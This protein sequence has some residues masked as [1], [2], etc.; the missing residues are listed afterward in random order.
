MNERASVFET[1]GRDSRLYDRYT[2]NA[3]DEFATTETL[4][5][6]QAEWE[7]F[8]VNSHGDIFDGLDVENPRE[9][10][11]IDTL[12]YDFVVDQV[13]EFAERQ[14][15]FRVVNQEANDN[16][17]ALSFD[18]QTLHESVVD[19]DAI[20]RT[21]DELLDTVDLVNSD[22]DFLRRLYESVI[23]NEMRLQL[24]EYYTPKG[25]AELAVGE[26]EVDDFETD[27]VLDPGCGSGIFLATCVDAKREALDL[28][29]G[30]LV[31][32]ITDT[33]YG[34]DLNPVAVKSAKL[35]YLLSLLPV[36]ADS[37]VDRL[38]LPVFLTDSLGLTRDDRIRFGDDTLDLTVDHLVGN[39]PWIT[40]G[41]LSESV[42]D[43]WRETYVTQLDLLPHDGVESRL[44]HGNDDISVPFLWV[45]IHHYLDEGGDASF[46]LKRDITKGPAG[47]LLRTQHVNSR[48]V[49]V[50][51]IHDFNR[52]RPFGDDVGV[53][54]AVYTLA[55]DSEPSFPIAVDSW[56]RGEGAT[57][58][59][60]AEAMRETLDYEETGMV[61][62]EEDDTSS[63]WV[64]ED[65]E[66]QALG[67]C[68]HDIRHGVKDDAKDV[69]GVE[70]SQLDELEHDHV[71]PYIQSKHVVK[72]GLFGHDLHLVPVC[73]A[74]E[75]NET[76]LQ[77]NC[78]KTYGYLESNRQT[79]EDRSS[80]WLDEGTFYNV[81][82]LGEYTWSDY[83]VVWC[84]LGFKPHFAVVSTV[85]DEDLDEKMVVPGDHF[86]FISTDDEY[87]AHFL[88]GLL[89]SS[90]YQTSLEGVASEGKSSLT[91][92][93]VSGLELP[94]Y[95]ETED[96]ERLA[97]LSM[98]AHEIVPEHTDVSKRTYNETSIEEL[99]VVQAEIDELVEEM[100]SERAGSLFPDVGQSTLASY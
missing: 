66:N 28:D 64:R 37:D 12:Y 96:S 33:V 17:D 9:S 23:S 95:R 86:M 11:F 90:V 71:Y 32:V 67:E 7:Q 27:T 87:E 24:G 68:A 72:Y 1:W 21:V 44:G 56:T 60:A 10:L 30:P 100:L 49:A 74:N 6:A 19:T 97:E 88:C 40:W 43:A 39:P 5:E 20:E 8:F 3:A 36:L 78:P 54:S 79:L 63:S 75:D 48:P 22:A 15:G 55:A 13:I 99:E 62:V 85:A 18:F 47:R 83:K 51:H 46:V 81:F 77:R 31:D 58:F 80:T 45:C 16:T 73:E 82:G 98:E 69:Y 93:V 29:P 2:S 57:S 65:A 94:E 70:R 50:R 38:E 35:S 4:Q 42:R 61:P 91:K 92:T 14:F 84:R 59:A 41:S 25:V 34:I 52:L 76:E 89:N 26:I 53:H